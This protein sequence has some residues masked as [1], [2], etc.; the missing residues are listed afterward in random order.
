MR[1]KLVEG[2]NKRFRKIYD[3]TYNNFN[4]LYIIAALFDP[5]DCLLVD[6]KYHVYFKQVIEAKLQAHR[7]QNAE[8]NAGI[9]PNNQARNTYRDQ[10]LR[11]RLQ[12]TNN[13]LEVIF[14]YIF[15]K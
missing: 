5:M 3:E 2:L 12:E 15:L 6:K 13:E 14:L 11:Q 7:N 8:P 1:D 4:A 9:I 10:L